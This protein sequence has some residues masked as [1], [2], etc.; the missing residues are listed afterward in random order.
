VQLAATFALTVMLTKVVVAVSGYNAS[1]CHGD[2]C[3]VLNENFTGGFRHVGS[4]MLR[5]CWTSLDGVYRWRDRGG[6][7]IVIKEPQPLG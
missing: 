7:H 6:M 3:I 4:A 2:T 1:T 5:V